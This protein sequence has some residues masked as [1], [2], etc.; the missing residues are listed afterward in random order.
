MGP[1]HGNPGPDA[2]HTG[3]PACHPG[4]LRPAAPGGGGW[5]RRVGDPPNGGPGPVWHTGAGSP[6][7][8]QSG[9]SVG[10]GPRGVSLESPFQRSLLRRGAPGADPA[11]P[12]L[13]RPSGAES[14]RG[15]VPGLF[16][17]LRPFGAAVR[18][19]GGHRRWRGEVPQR[20]GDLP[21]G[22]FPGAPAFAGSA[23]QLFRQYQRGGLFPD[24]RPVYPAGR[25]G[26]RS[27]GAVSRGPG[28]SGKTGGPGAGFWQP[29]GA[30][31]ESSPGQAAV[32][33]PDDPVSHPGGK[34]LPVPLPVLLQVRPGSQGAPSGG[35]GRPGSTAP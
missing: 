2:G 13:G 19:L 21:A 1:A 11:E 31:G 24:G 8:T 26:S 33:G 16:G 7:H 28:L 27:S 12:A 25:L 20:P 17:G 5:G 14:H 32:W 10:R 9:V 34:V 3:R 30:V 29:G 35:G 23:G 6:V 18:Q 22:D 4:A 15:T